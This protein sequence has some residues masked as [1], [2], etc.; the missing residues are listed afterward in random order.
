M[1]LNARG[2]IVIIIKQYT[3]V[4]HKKK[5]NFFFFSDDDQF[6]IYQTDLL[7]MLLGFFGQNGTNGTILISYFL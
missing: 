3:E 2:L 1:N 5:V 7:I 6:D 4:M